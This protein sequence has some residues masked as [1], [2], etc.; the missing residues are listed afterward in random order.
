[1]LCRGSL[2][3]LGLQAHTP[4][5]RCVCQCAAA[6]IAA[7]RQVVTDRSR[8][9]T[10]PLGLPMV[11]R[12]GAGTAA[13]EPHSRT[14]GSSVSQ[15][16]TWRHGSDIGRWVWSRSRRTGVAGAP[17]TGP[18]GPACSNSRRIRRL[19]CASAAS[20][21]LQGGSERSRSR[22][23]P[24]RWVH[25]DDDSSTA[26]ASATASA[27]E[28]YCADCGCLVNGGVTVTPCNDHPTAAAETAETP[29]GG[30]LTME[31]Y[32]CGDDRDPA[33][34]A[35]LMCHDDIT[36]CRVCIGCVRC[37]RRRTGG[38][39]ARTPPGVSPE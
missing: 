39:R 14:K 33:E 21:T 31:C 32:C 7:G 30:F 28:I 35:S 18:F 10:D 12:L 38:D 17:V 24:R 13:S 5:P 34:V 15:R 19:A 2:P 25:G 22:H 9:R 37:T 23:V 4:A 3:S 26:P 36:V 20:Q 29:D 16:E 1:M 8:S 27:M 6:W 11:R